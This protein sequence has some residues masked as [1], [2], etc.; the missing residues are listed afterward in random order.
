MIAEI[1]LVAVGSLL[2]VAGGLAVVSI[3][4]ALTHYLTK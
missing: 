2:G 3:I 4:N 1:A